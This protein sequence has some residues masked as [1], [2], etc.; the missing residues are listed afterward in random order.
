MSCC[1][2][3]AYTNSQNNPTITV[4]QTVSTKWKGMASEKVTRRI[5]RHLRSLFTNGLG[6][7]IEY[8]E[9]WTEGTGGVKVSRQAVSRAVRGDVRRMR[10]QT[11][12]QL[13][14]FI[15][16]E[17]EGRVAADAL[18]H[19]IDERRD[20]ST[21]IADD[22]HHTEV[23][24]LIRDGDRLRGVHEWRRALHMYS[25][26]LCIIQTGDVKQIPLCTIYHRLG[27]LYL[28][29]VGEPGIAR[30]FYES[31]LQNRPE[32]YQQGILLCRMAETYPAYR[33]GPHLARAV[34]FVNTRT[35]ADLDAWVRYLEA[36]QAYCDVDYARARQLCDPIIVGPE[37]PDDVMQRVKHLHLTLAG[38][39]HDGERIAAVASTTGQQVADGHEH[40][41]L[42]VAYLESGFPREAIK[43]AVDS[44]QAFKS[45]GSEGE[46]AGAHCKLGMYCLHTND[47]DRS[48]Q[49]LL[50]SLGLSRIS[51]SMCHLFLCKTWIHDHHEDGRLWAESMLEDLHGQLLSDLDNSR[52]EGDQSEPVPPTDMLLH[53]L[54]WPERIMRHS[55]ASEA[56]EAWCQVLGDKALEFYPGYTP[57]WAFSQPVSLAKA[58]G[59]P[60][61]AGWHEDPG[62]D[63]GAIHWTT[64]H[65]NLETAPYRGF[66]QMDMPRA[67]L[68]CHGDFTLQTAMHDGAAVIDDLL[69]CRA[70]AGDNHI[71]PTALGGGGILVRAD[72]HRVM[73]IFAHL[74]VPGDIICEAKIDDR[75]WA[76]GRGFL[77]DGTIYLRVERRG[78]RLLAYAAVEPDRWHPAGELDISGWGCVEVGVHG[79]PLV[80]LY[81]ITRRCQTRFWDVRFQGIAEPSDVSKPVATSPTSA[82]P[83]RLPTQEH[84]IS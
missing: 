25:D 46:T 33:M 19:E 71:A 54:G 67:Y 75:R 64:T 13:A 55:G 24:A 27:D 77:G 36:M 59:R 81:P 17:T 80:D 41:A 66:G 40:A 38:I 79:E 48:R 12:R 82:Q 69:R 28:L 11:A 50:T 1:N 51:R 57:V 72:R 68:R 32:S 78:D 14:G 8:V 31:A 65:L 42:A 44:L 7:T 83:V 18:L 37:L 58:N 43:H 21:A 15:E 61:K 16:A 53:R 45:L 35:E 52:P 74:Q 63:D 56:F 2:C 34:R 60:P 5:C 84:A 6:L 70:L 4:R 30:G 3:V 39:E 20:P 26:A 47:L 73:R 62:S 9:A 29:D 23:Q 22:E 10:D 49:Q 76:L